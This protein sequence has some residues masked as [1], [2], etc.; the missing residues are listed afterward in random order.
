M[1]RVWAMKRLVLFLMFTCVIRLQAL[2]PAPVEQNDYARLTTHEEVMAYCRGLA[3]SAAIV[4]LEI[5][6]TSV[7]GKPIPALLFSTDV[8]GSRRSSVPMV[9]VFC[10]QHGNEPSG[11]EAGLVL[12]RRLLEADTD[13][14]TNMDV[15]LIPQVNPDGGDADNRRNG[16]DVDLNRDHVLLSQ[17]ETRA[18]H[19]L[20]RK[21]RPEVTLDV[22]EFQGIS[23]WWRSHGFVREMDVMLGTVTNPAIDP[24]IHRFS[25]EVV[26]KETAQAM[27]ETPFRF[28]EYVVGTPFEGDRMRRSTVAIDDGRQS[29][30]ILGT[31]SFII[32][33]KR[34]GDSDN[35][36]EHR[37]KA[38]LAVMRGFLKCVA[39]HA[40]EIREQVW[41]VRQS[42]MTTPSGDRRIPIRVDHAPD[43]AEPAVHLPVLVLDDWRVETRAFEPF[44]GQ[45]QIKRTVSYPAAYHIP[46]N[47]KRLIGLLQRHGIALDMVEQ[48]MNLSVQQYRFLHVATR[49][50]EEL[51]MPEMD[52][53]VAERELT[54]GPGDVLVN[55]NQSARNLIV[56]LLEP[57]SSF[58]ILGPSGHDAFDGYLRTGVY[59]VSR[60]MAVSH[61]SEVEE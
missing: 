58:G 26:L 57:A 37:V 19:D 25:R 31:L 8:F 42:M 9:M 7:Q 27:E 35:R 2:D 20:F 44:H 21:W 41:L 16:N 56:L 60:V 18:L 10:Q 43:P 28:H 47:R 50:E 30:G 54:A 40:R 12:A 53:V 1:S 45:V 46:A 11:K 14:L 22:H 4:S 33:G 34:F 49:M 5:I 59:P 17:P 48:T 15:I 3:D 36:I 39:A 38:Q 6:G 61:V 55:L 13:L 52:M 23:R 51:D 24:W 32:E 29:L